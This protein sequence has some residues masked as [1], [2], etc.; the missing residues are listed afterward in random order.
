MVGLPLKVILYLVVLC[1]SLAFGI[2]AM[3]LGMGGK[4]MVRYTQNRRYVLAASSL[5]GF[6]IGTMA[7]LTNDLLGMELS[8]L[9]LWL[10]A[11]TGISGG[12][13]RAFS[14]KRGAR[15]MKIPQV[16]SDEDLRRMLER[17]G[18]GKLVDEEQRG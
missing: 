7:I 1:G 16:G 15:E 2:Q 8:C 18:L 12:I 17:R 14:G 11:Y 6:C 3:F 13:L 5:L 4:V 10:V 9:A